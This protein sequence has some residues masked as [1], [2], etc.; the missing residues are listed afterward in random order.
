MN[1]NPLQGSTS[2][3]KAELIRSTTP[4]PTGSRG[5]SI[6]PLSDLTPYQI[7]MMSLLDIPASLTFRPKGSVD[8]RIAYTKYK[9]YLQA[10]STMLRMTSEGTWSLRKP[11]AEEL[12]EIFM[13]KSVWHSS[14]QKF[15]PM[16]KDYPLLLSW[17][18]NAEDAPSNIDVFGEE[19]NPYTF[20]DFQ[21]FI[22]RAEVM[23]KGK[24]KRKAKGS[25]S[26]GAQ[27]KKKGKGAEKE[28]EKEKEKGKGKGK[29]KAK[30]DSDSSSDSIESS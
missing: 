8:L 4:T 12:V 13:S 30:K 28:K 24:G 17:L 9:G 10:Q 6:A 20:K 11:K 21:A 3:I 14:Y 1:L 15:F 16:A 7:D 27:Q 18:D 22:N 19:K 23:R 5:T 26:E 29:E 25:V 2:I